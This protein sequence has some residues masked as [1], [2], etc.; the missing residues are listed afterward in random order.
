L[1]YPE[2]QDLRVHHHTGEHF[3]RM[4]PDTQGRCTIAEVD[5]QVGLLHSWLR[6]WY[7]GTLL[8]LPGEL[9][10]R[11]EKQAQLVKK[12]AQEIGKQSEQILQLENRADVLANELR[13]KDA[14]LQQSLDLLRGRIAE[15]A[16]QAGRTDILTRLP[17][18][19]DLTLLSQWLSELG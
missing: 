14:F 9:E 12:Q 19:S 16:R 3:E 5:L 11:M 1:F 8:E 4:E 10:D 17:E 7:R 13:L 2:A 15:R 6:Y 18:T